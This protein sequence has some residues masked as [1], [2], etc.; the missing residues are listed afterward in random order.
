[1]PQCILC[2]RYSRHN[3]QQ[4]HLTNENVHIRCLNEYVWRQTGCDCPGESD[5]FICPSGKRYPFVIIDDH[6]N[7]TRVRY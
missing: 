2:E 4:L 5:V 3:M 7:S 1:M 6:V